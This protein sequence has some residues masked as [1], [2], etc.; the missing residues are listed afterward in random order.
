[1]TMFPYIIAVCFASLTISALAYFK[2]CRIIVRGEP[3]KNEWWWKVGLCFA[4][5]AAVGAIVGLADILFSR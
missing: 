5:I 4:D 3:I 2:W 1:M